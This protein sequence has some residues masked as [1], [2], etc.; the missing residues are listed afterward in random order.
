MSILKKFSGLIG[1]K[2]HHRRL[3][4]RPRPPHSPCVELTAVVLL[5]A[6]DV[7]VIAPD[8]E[9]VHLGRL[10]PAL[11]GDPLWLRPRGKPGRLL[12]LHRQDGVDVILGKPPRHFLRLLCLRRRRRHLLRNPTLSPIKDLVA[13]AGTFFLFPSSSP[14]LER[15]ICEEPW[16]L[17]LW[18]GWAVCS[19][20]PLYLL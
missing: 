7:V 16:R 17:G 8:D 19:T 14:R 20:R 3:A 10:A 13:A 2:I 15:S 9:L 1:I 18:V 6:A 12:G 5:D 11:L 4:P